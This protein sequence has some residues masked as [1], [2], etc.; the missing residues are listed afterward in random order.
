MG[1]SASPTR[2]SFFTNNSLTPCE[3]NTWDLWQLYAAVDNV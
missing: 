1:Q 2:H 3:S